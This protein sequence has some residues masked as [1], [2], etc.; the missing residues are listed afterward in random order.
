MKLNAEQLRERYEEVLNKLLDLADDL[1]DNARLMQPEEYKE[2]AWAQ[3]RFTNKF[4]YRKF[5][6]LADGKE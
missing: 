2:W 4:V 5:E 1:A 6:E 3:Q